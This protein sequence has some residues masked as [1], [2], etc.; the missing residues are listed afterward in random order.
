MLNTNRKSSNNM[1]KINDYPPI[2]QTG[3]KTINEASPFLIEPINL[4]ENV[5]Y[6]KLPQQRYEQPSF[7]FDYND[8]KRVHSSLDKENNYY[9]TRS[10]L[11]NNNISDDLIFQEVKEK[12]K[13][14]KL[15]KQNYQENIKEEMKKD[16][17][18]YK[19]GV[20]LNISS[21]EIQEPINISNDNINDLSRAKSADKYRKNPKKISKY[22]SHL[23]RNYLNK[24]FISKDKNGII[25]IKKYQDEL[26][27]I[28]YNNRNNNYQMDKYSKTYTNFFKDQRKNRTEINI[29]NKYHIKKNYRLCNIYMKKLKL[30]ITRLEEYFIQSFKVFFYF[31]IH[32]LKLYIKITGIKKLKNLSLLSNK[33][34][35]NSKDDNSPSTINNITSKEFN[36]NKSRNGRLFLQIKTNNKKHVTFN[37]ECFQNNICK[38]PTNICLNSKVKDNSNLKSYQNLSTAFNSSEINTTN[39]NINLENYSNISSMVNV[40]NIPI[41][42]KGIENS[43]QNRSLKTEVLPENNSR[44][45]NIVK[46]NNIIKNGNEYH[47]HKKDMIYIKPMVNYTKK[48]RTEKKTNNKNYRINTDN[49]N[50]LSIK[51]LLIKRKFISESPNDKL[52][53]I[54]IKDLQSKDKRINIF[55]KYITSETVIKN[56]IKSKIRRKL[57]SNK[58]TKNIFINNEINFLKKIS[59]ESF[60][61]IP[62][63]SILKVDIKNNVNDNIPEKTKDRSTKLSTFKDI[64]ANIINKYKLYFSEYFFDQLKQSNNKINILCNEN[65]SEKD[66]ELNKINISSISNKIIEDNDNEIVVEEN[67]SMNN[68]IDN[69]LLCYNNNKIETEKY[70]SEIGYID[71]MISPESSEKENSIKNSIEHR[72][73]S[74]TYKMD[75]NNYTVPFIKKFNKEKEKN[76][77]TKD[78]YGSIDENKLFNIKIS[79]HK[80]CKN[81]LKNIRINK[82]KIEE[83]KM[84]KIKHI[85]DKI[86]NKYSFT[87]N[88]FD[89]KKYNL[90][91]W[92]KNANKPKFSHN[93]CDSKY[94]INKS[95]ENN[96]EYNQKEINDKKNYKDNKCKNNFF[97]QCGFELSK[98]K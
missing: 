42:N 21:Y 83:A 97:K 14:L 92:R 1:F 84:D 87:M 59:I 32:R 73:K 69:I 91:L 12:E 67:Y 40:P 17:K 80:E 93:I 5:Y 74:T 82:S 18:T 28:P 3:Y 13:Q 79:K 35:N 38:T 15:L 78:K 36:S 54:I 27:S 56:F 33:F 98:N 47:S 44:N 10:Y 25:N 46:Y 23:K 90:H 53:E 9:N 39:P 30:F 37:Q 41:F 95:K 65:I 68:D 19:Y 43:L 31:F 72:R 63:I 45:K 6:K 2:Y 48:L 50:E 76:V 66:N 88:S 61:F 86:K 29:N 4:N 89:L 49:N 7:E 81:V 75:N 62:V 26:E 24:N 57:M 70:L 71:K 85:F 8:M 22:F 94:I 58:S 60:E 77:L 52:K 34:Q 55:I 16:I 96:K 20:N 64:I 51:S 11:F